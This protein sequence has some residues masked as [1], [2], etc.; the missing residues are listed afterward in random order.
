ME[1]RRISMAEIVLGKP[2]RWDV[3]DGNN[4]LLLTKGFVVDR[5][6]QVEVLLERGRVERGLQEEGL[7]VKLVPKRAEKSARPVEEKEAPSALRLINQAY[8]RLDWLLF[9]LP[10]ETAA[11]A[12]VFE[13]VEL[14]SLATDINRDVALACILLNQNGDYAVRHGIDT[15]IV[16][17]LAARSLDKSPGQI[18]SLMAAALTMNVAMVPVQQALQNKKDGLTESE[19]RVIKRHPQEGVELLQDAGVTDTD[20]LGCVLDHHENEDGSGYPRGRS[21]SEITES[22][23]I[24]AIADRYCARVAAR[25]YRKT[26]LPN[27]ALRDILLVDKKNI[28]PSLIA[29]FI[30]ELGTYPAGTFVRLENGEIG[31]VTGRGATTTMPIVHALVG[32]RGEPR[33]FAVR[34]DTSVDPHGIRE[35][36]YEEQA[37]IRFSMQQLWGDAAKL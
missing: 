6:R 2:L 34:R 4:H 30:R 12:E 7:F 8:E 19:I 22:T 21:G 17:L 20:W 3:Y 28:D 13:I 36:L 35:V 24:L 5:P 37:A 16:A 29:G 27:A 9:N 14:L 31:V 10:E 32:P 33:S 25:E 26:L 15:A 18:R 23:K 11:E 1:R